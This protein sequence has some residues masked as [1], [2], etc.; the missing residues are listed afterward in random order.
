MIHPTAQAPNPLPIDKL[1]W[2]EMTLELCT[3]FK[4]KPFGPAVISFTHDSIRLLS[5]RGVGT[6]NEEGVLS[7]GPFFCIET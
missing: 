5:F 2:F 7:N 1:D 6:F 4:G 3:T